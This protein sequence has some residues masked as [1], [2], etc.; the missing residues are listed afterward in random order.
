MTVTAA[1][2]CA[3]AA[4]M[5]KSFE[6]CTGVSLDATNLLLQMGR[7][8]SLDLEH[9]DD[10]SMTRFAAYTQHPPRAGTVKR[11]RKPELDSKVSTIAWKA[12]PGHPMSAPKDM[13]DACA[14]FVISN[15][16][17]D[18]CRGISKQSTLKTT[19]PSS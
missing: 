16:D 13:N 5:V 3:P 7:T 6:A 19:S 8:K 12:T 10:S 15:S 4:G 11:M 17:I 18:A 2:A 1:T 14:M 9:L